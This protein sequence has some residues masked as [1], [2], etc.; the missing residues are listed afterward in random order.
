VPVCVCTRHLCPQVYQAGRGG[1]A[2]D[3]AKALRH[4]SSAAGLGDASAHFLL[5]H[6]FHGR[7]AAQHAAQHHQDAAASA[8]GGGAPASSGVSQEV[9]A[10]EV[11]AGEVPA[12]EEPAGA[13]VRHLEAAV[14]GGHGGAAYYYALLHRNGDESLG[15]PFDK[16]P[17]LGEGPASAGRESN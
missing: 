3:G 8:S 12:G 5:A 14:A 2:V 11:P 6:H 7:A 17:N 13:C 10:G 16:G 9:P 4:F 1:V 15:H